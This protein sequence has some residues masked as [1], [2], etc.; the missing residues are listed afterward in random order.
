M[1]R[2]PA[3][4]RGCMQEACTSLCKEVRGVSQRANL[5]WVG[6][7][8]LGEPALPH[9]RRPQSRGALLATW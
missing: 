5:A 6:M 2:A 1:G 4:D 9:S 8:P 3:E 7:R